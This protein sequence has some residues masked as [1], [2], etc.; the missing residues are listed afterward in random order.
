M[1]AL[2]DAD[3]FRA[4]IASLDPALA[5]DNGAALDIVG[6]D[7]ML[8]TKICA[9]LSDTADYQLV[10][11]RQVLGA[12]HLV[13]CRT[14]GLTVKYH[15]LVVVRSHGDGRLRFADAFSYFT[16]TWVSEVV[17]RDL[18][19]ADESSLGAAVNLAAVTSLED[20][21]PDQALAAFEHLPEPLRTERP[22]T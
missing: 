16:A 21:H 20:D 3:G 4:R 11:A 2:V 1:K 8:A 7:T 5:K 22:G 19:R 9:W 12:T 6:P 10:R 15:E 18:A 17:V 13:F 14:A